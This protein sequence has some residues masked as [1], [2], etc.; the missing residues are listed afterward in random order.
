MS[1]YRPESDCDMMSASDCFNLF[2]G[3]YFDKDGGLHMQDFLIGSC[4]RYASISLIFHLP[5]QALTL[6]ATEPVVTVG[7]EQYL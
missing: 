1:R 4:I 3:V 7:N 5:R 2:G 6:I